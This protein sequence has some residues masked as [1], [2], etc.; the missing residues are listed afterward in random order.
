M[1]NR[2]LFENDYCKI[3]ETPKGLWI[4]EDKI[5]NTAMEVDNYFDK[6]WIFIRK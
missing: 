6:N 3:V 5:L 2:T 4:R 1:K